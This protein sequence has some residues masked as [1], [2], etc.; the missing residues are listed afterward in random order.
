[1]K[2]RILFTLLSMFFVT[3]VSAQEETEK[4]TDIEGST[5]H[6]LFSR[7]PNFFIVEYDQNFDRIDIVGTGGNNISVEGMKTYIMYQ[8]DKASGKKAP[9][10]FQVL[11]NYEVAIKKIGGTLIHT[12]NDYLSTFSL[13][14]N[15]QTTWVSVD[16]SGDITY[17]FIVE[18]QAME[19]EITANDLYKKLSEDG[20]VSL[21]I[22]FEIGKSIIKSE[23]QPLY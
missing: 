4:L 6:P 8:F 18:E 7:L 23:S 9:S 16:T 22:N 1:M 2:I 14:K 12:N 5:D 19:Q 10:A 3:A 15:G 20:T 17:L 11:K 21:Y 13:K